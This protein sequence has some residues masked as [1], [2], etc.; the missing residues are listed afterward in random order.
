MALSSGTK[1]GPYEI[2]SPLGAGG[3]G[4]VY[5]ARDT[6]LDRTVAIKIL[7]REL[8]NDPIHKQRFEREA[9]NISSLNHPHICTLHDIGSHNGTDFLV[10]EY[11][12]GESLAN[13]LGKGP[14]PVDQVLKIGCEISGALDKAHRNGIIH[15][16]I[17]PGNIMLTK[18]GAKLLDFG[19]ARSTKSSNT[20]ATLTA[21]SPQQS[22]VT[23]QGTIVGTFQYM[24]PEQVEGKELDSRSDI[25]SLGAVLYEMLT[26][27]RAFPGKS[28]L[29][30]ASAILEKDP[31][32]ISS[33]KPLTPPALEHVIRR[34]LAKDPEDRW[35][36]AKDLANE[37]KWVSDSGSQAG[38]LPA[39]PAG[40]RT[41]H[42]LPWIISGVL[43]LL[44]VAAFI[45]WHNS[46]PQ[47]ET[48]YFFAPFPF[49]AND[50]AVAPNGHSIAV[51]SHLE[52]SRKNLLWIYELGSQE[53][54]TL[55]GTEGASFP[56]W[57][58]DGHSLG[59]FADGKLKKLD[60]SGGPVQILCDAPTGRGGT[61]NKDDVILFTPSGQQQVG[62]FQISASGG[63]PK[64]IT[65]P[66]Q[67]NAETTHRWPMFLPDGKHFLYLAANISGPRDRDAIFI[68]SLGTNEK[69]FVVKTAA[70]AA[71]VTSGYFLFYRDK[72]LFAQRFDSK[73]FEFT[74][75]PIAVLNDIQYSARISKAVFA[76]SH[77]GVLVA[78]SSHG[79]SISKLV[80]LDRK[81]NEVGVVGKPDAYSNVFLAPNGNSVALDKTDTGS[82]NTDIWTYE[83]QHD[84]IKRL[85][86]EP[87][88]DAVPVWSP[89][90]TKFV[91]TSNR[92]L[93]FDL[94]LKNANGA[95]VEK[96]IVQGGADKYPDDWSRDGKFILYTRG[97]N[98]WFLSLPDFKSTLFLKAPSVLKNGQFS[99]DGKWVAYASNESGTWEI[100][101]TSFPEPRGK[102]QISSGGGE[103]PRWRGDGKELFFLSSGAKIMATPV[104]TG[105]NFDAG[106]PVALFQANPCEIVATSEQMIYDVSKDGQRFLINTQVPQAEA[107]PMSIVLNWPAKLNN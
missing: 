3:M 96:P 42:L 106:A 81:G 55:A 102:W 2:Q 58:A 86:F 74:G 32:P 5:R 34:C 101:V 95:Q 53:A 44:L 64:Q 83:L 20:L 104:T 17:K 27:Q 93:N 79:V 26:G 88:I 4:E 38:I 103:Q 84:G 39:E 22:P 67:N 29:S 30:V 97:Y 18:S 107:H 105:T 8:S 12:E 77:D 9:R 28:Q 36:N 89:D 33:L 62:L 11:V 10:M 23:E 82:Q 16:D 85:T 98:L 100:Y 43:A 19:L 14:L 25:F 35:Q 48:L 76:A 13:R 21:T 40:N 73:T 45:W 41:R 37:L 70:N 66:D 52:S 57:S 68:G 65:F 47:Q 59:F 78:Q 50:V 54:R 80:W 1:L 75:N 46:K 31:A 99:P 72:T 7:S 91:F 69:R 51:V 71:F 56:F 60:A 87:A 90:A 61:W 6:R 15:R 63:T 24:S 92:G 49:P 94:Y